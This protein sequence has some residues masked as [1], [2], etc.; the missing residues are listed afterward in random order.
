MTNDVMTDVSNALA[1][2][3]H[4]PRVDRGQGFGEPPSFDVVTIPC[5]AR[6]VGMTGEAMRS[7]MR[8]GLTVSDVVDAFERMLAAEQKRATT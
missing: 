1:Q 5:G 2:R 8:A 4:S 7:A 6:T 3:G